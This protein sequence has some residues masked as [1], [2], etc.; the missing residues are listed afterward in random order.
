[1]VGDKADDVG[2]AVAAGLGAV[3]VRTGHGA[4]Q[5]AA[6]RRRWPA[7]PRLAYAPDLPAAVDHILGETRA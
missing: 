4:D 1:M 7:R 6:V 3:L 5:E 2:L